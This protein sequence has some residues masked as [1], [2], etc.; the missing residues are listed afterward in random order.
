MIA[1]NST[2][3]EFLKT[4]RAAKRWSESKII[5]EDQYRIIRSAYTT[6]L[7]SPN[8]FIRVALFLFT[9]ICLL[10]VFG[11]IVTGGSLNSAAGVRVIGIFSICMGSACI[12]LLEY[13]IKRKHLYRAGIDDAML[14]GGLAFVITGLIAA[15]FADHSPQY[16][17]IP[18]LIAFP[19]LLGGVIRYADV[20]VTAA[21]YVCWLGIVYV[22]L[23]D[24]NDTAKLLLPFIVTVLSLGIY[25][26]VK[27][28]EGN[29]QLRAWEGCREM[30]EVFSLCTLYLGGNYYVVRHMREEFLWRSLGAGEDIPMALVFYALTLIVP[31]VY[32][33]S[34]LHKKDRVMLRVGLCA[35]GF[36][37][38]TF[39]YYFSLGHP[40]IILIIAGGILIGAALISI[41]YLKSSSG[42]F[43]H[44]NL[45]KSRT[46]SLEMEGLV[47]SQAVNATPPA[48][49]KKFEGGGGTFGG[50]GSQNTW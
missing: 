36:S 22:P 41:R 26:V 48:V 9:C 7:Y 21:M 10:G 23:S 20:L 13:L 17:V 40:E 45:L 15:F 37:A 50:G 46:D 8:F 43:T 2:W 3:R 35:A 34:G 12:V 30:V 33:I 1:Y 11:L 4:A 19:F 31:V 6:P 18:W 49:E 32:V 29:N 42:A 44:E 24:G 5:S 47:L 14:Y 25:I 39:K 38:F 27:R 16:K 28:M